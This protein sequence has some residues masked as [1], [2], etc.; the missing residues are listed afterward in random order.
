MPRLE[1][2]T[3]YL[4]PIIIQRGLYVY[5]LDQMMVPVADS[6]FLV[7][8]NKYNFTV[9]NQS[10]VGIEYFEGVAPQLRTLFSL[11]IKNFVLNRHL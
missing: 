10:L 2:T 4:C 9:P 1:L 5:Q 3:A 11:S 8:A 7:F 6:L